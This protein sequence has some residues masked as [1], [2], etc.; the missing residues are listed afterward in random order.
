MGTLIPLSHVID[1]VLI[2]NLLKEYTPYATLLFGILSGVALT[3]VNLPVS[4]CYGIA[5]ASIPYVSKE[6]DIVEQNKK[7]EKS[8]MITLGV[9]LVCS[10]VAY[11][12]SEQIISILYTSLKGYQKT[13]AVNLLRLLSPCI[14]LLSL[15]QTQNALL[16]G[17]NKLYLP[18]VSLVVGIATK[19]TVNIILLKNPNFNIYGG[20]IGVIACYF[21]TCLINLIVLWTIKVRN[22]NKTYKDKKSTN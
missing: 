15:V 9:S 21:V 19:I 12:F 11:F 5:T 16:I 1:S 13:T 8:L 18:S 10:L 7:L 2:I 3:I 6:T 4:V 20:A 17:K 22:A 14:V